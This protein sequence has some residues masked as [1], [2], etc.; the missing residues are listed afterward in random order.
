MKHL[1]KEVWVDDSAVHAR[2]TDGLQASYPF[3]M[4]PRLQN[5][6]SVQRSNFYLSYSGIH[7][8]DIDE[9]LSFEG[10]FSHAGLCQ[11]TESEDS[12]CYEID[13]LSQAG[14]DDSSSMVAE[15]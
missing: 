14:E 3:S 1:I 8:P 6:S 12:V 13:Y 9:D 10:M 5:A 7:W 15:E 4:W 2:T 11:R